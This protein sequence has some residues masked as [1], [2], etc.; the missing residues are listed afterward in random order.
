MEDLFA[1]NGWQYKRLAYEP[2]L[3][4]VYCGRY[5]RLRFRVLVFANR[6]GRVL[7]RHFHYHYAHCLQQHRLA[8]IRGSVRLPADTEYGSRRFGRRGTSVC[9]SR[10]CNDAHRIC[11]SVKP[12]CVTDKHYAFVRQAATRA[13][14]TVSALVNGNNHVGLTSCILFNIQYLLQQLCSDALIL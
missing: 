1:I 12:I 14:A 8:G 7:E 10:R 2:G 6:R 13:S 11:L 3:G 9:C 5:Q 4:Q